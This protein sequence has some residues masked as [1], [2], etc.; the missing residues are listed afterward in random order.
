MRTDQ[1]PE[2]GFITAT[3]VTP[4]E[5]VTNAS[6]WP[7]GERREARTWVVFPRTRSP[8]QAAAVSVVRSAHPPSGAGAAPEEHERAERGGEDPGGPARAALA[9]PGRAWRWWRIREG[10]AALV[11]I[12]AAP[13][14]RAVALVAGRG[15]PWVSRPRL[16]RTCFSSRA[17][18]RVAAYRSSGS[19]ARH[20]PT[21][22]TRGGG[23]LGLRSSSDRAPP[24]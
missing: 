2:A 3:W 7:S 21:I 23:T 8:P 10:A 15:T 6:V 16:S 24:R 13:S 11:R 14:T 20:R 12:V 19:F 4:P 17:R 18:S 1:S 22:Q 5:G 9:A